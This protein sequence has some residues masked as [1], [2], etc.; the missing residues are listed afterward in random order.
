[1]QPREFFAIWAPKEVIW[2]RWAK[3]VVFSQL[4]QNRVAAAVIRNEFT[5]NTDNIPTPNN[6]T[7]ILVNLPGVESIELGMALAQLGHRPVPLYNCCEGANAIIPMAAIIDSLVSATPILQKLQL[8]LLAPPAFLIDANRMRDIAKPSPGDFDNRWLVFPQDFPS[9]KF[10]LSQGIQRVLLLQRN[11]TPESDLAHVLLLWQQQ[12]IQ[13]LRQNFSVSG[14]PV[15]LKVSRP[16][17]FRYFWYRALTLLSLKRN[18]AGGFGSVIP[19]ESTT[20]GG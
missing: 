11:D 17:W 15:P 20:G 18:S 7:L 19:D 13:L 8:P 16:R 9:G 10:L 12:G 6:S 2:S 3:P 14:I 4:T 1:M 5:M